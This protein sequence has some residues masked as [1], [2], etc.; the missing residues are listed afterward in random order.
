[1]LLSFNE[2]IVNRSNFFR[3]AFGQGISTFIYSIVYM[4]TF[5]Y[6]QVL[7]NTSK[8]YEPEDYLEELSSGLIS[9]I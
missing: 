3:L 2:S 4:N 6:I 5:E 7:K 8:I 9:D 1:M